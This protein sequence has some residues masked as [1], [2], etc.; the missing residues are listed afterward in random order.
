MS[1]ISFYLTSSIVELLKKW[2]QLAQVF[3]FLFSLYS[4]KYYQHIEPNLKVPRVFSYSLKIDN[5]Y[6]LLR[7]TSFW[8]IYIPDNY[9]SLQQIVVPFST[10]NLSSEWDKQKSC[11]F[12]RSWMSQTE[13]ESK[14]IFIHLWTFTIT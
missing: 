3:L 4:T 2:H 9:N 13:D 5:A 12:D 14:T 1:I 10:T 6:K 8:C 11:M 7:D